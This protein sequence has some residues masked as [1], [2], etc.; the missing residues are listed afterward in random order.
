MVADCTRDF[1]P[2]LPSLGGN[3]DRLMRNVGN[4]SDTYWGVTISRERCNWS[5]MWWRCCI[6]QFDCDSVR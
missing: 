3:R 2:T 1:V 5:A 4:L 6:F